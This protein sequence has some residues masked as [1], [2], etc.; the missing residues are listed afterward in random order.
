MKKYNLV[1]FMLAMIVAA[2]SFTA[3]GGSD[4]DEIDGGGSSE[5]V[6][7]WDIVSNVQYYSDFPPEYDEVN[8]A[9]WVFTATQVEVHDPTDLLNGKGVGYTYN[10]S[11]KE[12]KV[13]GWPIYT[14]LE[15]TSTTLKMQSVIIQG[16]YNIITLK[17]R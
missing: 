2:L 10:S 16:C 11:T 9:Y 7:T 14:V 12:L 6:G 5:L 15:L 3:C 13:V 1:L 4:D 17:K 8:G